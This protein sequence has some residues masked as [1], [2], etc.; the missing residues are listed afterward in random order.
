MA[1]QDPTR[2]RRL[3]RAATS[4]RVTR[5]PGPDDPTRSR[6]LHWA[7]LL[8]RTFGIDALDCPRCGHRMELIATICDPLVARKI[9]IH[10]GLAFHP[11]PPELAEGP[12]PWQPQRPLPF[13]A[14]DPIDPCLD[15]PAFLDSPLSATRTWSPGIDPPSARSPVARLYVLTPHG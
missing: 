4:T 9:L 11:P 5:P 12:P 10:L 14:P 13:H 2:S 7:D 6:R 15:P 3:T 8:R 1:T